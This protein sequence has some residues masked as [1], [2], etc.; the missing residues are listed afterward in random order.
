MRWFATAS[1]VALALLAAC[2]GRNERPDNEPGEAAAPRA[3]DCVP[4]R[5]ERPPEDIGQTPPERP[6]PADAMA[7]FDG[8]G[9]GSGAAM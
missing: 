6:A 4:A 2:G 5:W 7:P 1:M 8:S 9:E 3:P